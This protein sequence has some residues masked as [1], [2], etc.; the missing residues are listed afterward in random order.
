[1]VNYIYDYFKINFKAINEA[2]EKLNI[3][4]YNGGSFT[5]NSVLDALIMDDAILDMEAQKLSA[6]TLRVKLV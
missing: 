5:T 1:M 6:M 3:P 4:K 2:N